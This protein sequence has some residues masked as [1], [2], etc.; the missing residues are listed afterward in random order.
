MGFFVQLLEAVAV[1][2]PDSLTLVLLTLAFFNLY[3]IA[4][5]LHVAGTLDPDLALG[6]PLA[7]GYLVTIA[8]DILSSMRPPAR[9]RRTTLVQSKPKV[10]QARRESVLGELKA[11]PVKHGGMLIK[12]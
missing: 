1:L 8:I 10:E 3:C 6:I 4:M 5:T 12:S 11:R 2:V 7:V 9:R